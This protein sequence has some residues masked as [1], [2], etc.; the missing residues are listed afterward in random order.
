VG[1]KFYDQIAVGPV[2]NI[3]DYPRK[4]GIVINFKRIAI[5]PPSVQ[6]HVANYKFTHI[7]SSVLIFKN[8]AVVLA[9]SA[10]TLISFQR[11]SFKKIFF[12]RL[13]FAKIKPNRLTSVL[14]KNP[15][16]LRIA[17]MLLKS[18]KLSGK[19]FQIVPNR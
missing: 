5:R 13:V 2:L 3:F 19:L 18:P 8:F 4:R 12:W 14:S 15:G 10:V 9:K 16:G 1:H 11:L 6:P 17:L 7:S